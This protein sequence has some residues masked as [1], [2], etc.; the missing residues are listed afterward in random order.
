M[1]NCGKIKFE[2]KK[3]GTKV[4]KYIALFL[5]ICSLTLAACDDNKASVEPIEIQEM[6]NFEEE[7]P[8]TQQMITD[9]GDVKVIEKVFSKARELG[10][11]ED[12]TIPPQYTV[13]L[14]EQE[15]YLW[16]DGT[17]I[18]TIAPI[19]DRALFYNI[20]TSDEFKEIIGFE[21]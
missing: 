18:G 3:G 9:A 12:N 6:I 11:F 17:E 1:D 20:K 16:I 10:E 8:N 15:Y 13:K 2:L 14:G 4:K 21:H 19:E 7:K 5:I